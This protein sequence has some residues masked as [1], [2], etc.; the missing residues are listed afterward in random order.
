MIAINQDVITYIKV[1]IEIYKT[2]THDHTDVCS[3]YLFQATAITCKVSGM[4]GQ[5]T[6]PFLET[7]KISLDRQQYSDTLEL[8]TYECTLL[9]EKPCCRSSYTEVPSRTAKDTQA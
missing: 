4:V 1:N 6:S 5:A 2:N 7:T 9:K 8:Y 3:L